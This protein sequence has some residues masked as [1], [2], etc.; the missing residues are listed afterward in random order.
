MGGA[1]GG[2]DGGREG[3]RNVEEGQES[4]GRRGFA[5][6]VDAIP[7]VPFKREG[8]EREVK[9]EQRIVVDTEPWSSRTKCLVVLPSS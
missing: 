7:Q 4:L 5:G 1:V 8:R 6:G 2:R 3:G 9:E